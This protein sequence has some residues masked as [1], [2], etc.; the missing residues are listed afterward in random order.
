MPKIFNIDQSQIKTSPFP[1][2]VKDGFFEENLF[3]RL[4]QEFPKYEFFQRKIGGQFSGG[5]ID[6]QKGNP[7]LNE[8][9]QSSAVWKGVI[10]EIIS[11]KSFKLLLETFGHHIVDFGGKIDL[12]REKLVDRNDFIPKKPTLHRG[13]RKVYRETGMRSLAYKIQE[14]IFPYDFYLRFMTS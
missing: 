9:L 4:S 12:S 2:F 1:H 6:A 10:D 8:F 5:R 13:I 7:W 3:I 14:K 11:K